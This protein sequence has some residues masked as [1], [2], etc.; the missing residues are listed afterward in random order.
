[1]LGKTPLSEL[2]RKQYGDLLVI[3]EL[4]RQQQ[5]MYET[6]THRADGRIVSISQP[7]VRPIVRGKA[8]AP[9]EFGAKFTI[10]V[11]DGYVFLD[12]VSWEAYNEGK[13]LIDAIERYRERFGYYPKSV[14]ADKIYR[15]RENLKFC[16]SHGIRLSGPPLGRPPKEPRDR[17]H[18]ERQSRK[19][20]I[21]RIPVEGKFGNGKRRYNLDC[22]KEKLP[23]TSETKIGVVVL[24][25]NL[26]KIMRD[27]LFTFFLRPDSTDRLAAA[28]PFIEIFDQHGP[29]KV[30]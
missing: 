6:S 26:E 3:S 4:F 11:V 27:L 19:D 23:D 16:K 2:S 21:A 30:A 1:L 12:R 15:N 24:V 25:L 18:L 8:G 28:M 9:V 10:S 5:M 7:H 20:E 14:H 29:L 17:K 13:D 22:I